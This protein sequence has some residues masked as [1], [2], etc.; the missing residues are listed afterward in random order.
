MSAAKQKYLK[1]EDG[2]MISPITSVKSIYD[3]QGG[4]FKLYS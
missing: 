2:N 4:Y 3:E 1:D